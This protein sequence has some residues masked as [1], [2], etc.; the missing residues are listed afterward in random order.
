M[1][2]LAVDTVSIQPYIFGSNR[3]RENIGASYLVARATDLAPGSWP[4]NALP[5]P[6]N[7][8]DDGTFVEDAHIEDGALACEVLYAGGGNTVLIARDDDAARRFT[9]ALSRQLLEGAPGLDAVVGRAPFSWDN[10]SLSAAVGA[11]LKDAARLK[12]ADAPSAELLGLGVTALCGSTRLPATGKPQKIGDDVFLASSATHAKLNAVHRA[13]EKL[14]DMRR[15]PV[16]YDYPTDLDHLGRSR[17]EASYVA[18]VHAD[19]NGVGARVE[20]IG[21]EY[22]HAS[23]AGN[24]AYSKRM[25]AFS[26]AVRAAGT[27]ALMAVID[28]LI[29]R[30]KNGEILHAVG[31]GPD[32]QIVARIELTRAEGDKL[33]LPFRPLVFGG[34]DVT[35]VCDGRLGLAL[36]TAYLEEFGRQTARPDRDDALGG[37]LSACAGVAIVKSRYPFARAYALSEELARSAKAYRA[38]SEAD[39]PYLDWHLATSGLA[40]ALKVIRSREYSTAEERR[41]AALKSDDD[42][43]QGMLTLRPVAF[44]AKGQDEAR[45]WAVTR[46][47]LAAF[48]GEVRDE[49]KDGDQ[50]QGWLGRRNKLKALRDAL[51]QGEDAVKHFR[52]AYLD[53]RLLPDLGVGSDPELRKTGWTYNGRC[54]YFDAVELSDLYIPLEVVEREE[55]AHANS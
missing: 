23:G 4:L 51:R 13:R 7:V 49:G 37:P 32:E 9:R 30:I 14:G 22:E 1:I 6:H 48:Q 20:A 54:A 35:F 53:D 34:D 2:V 46:R 41:Q 36:A 44:G 42:A 25:R 29:A 3:L 5:Q 18:V 26:G 52:T 40:G 16:A 10:G 31:E 24:R 19:G 8:R 47:G 38:A 15:L 28:R 50:D 55:N 43:V 27:E 21:K 33:Y 11:A 39:G 45:S 12:A 17:E